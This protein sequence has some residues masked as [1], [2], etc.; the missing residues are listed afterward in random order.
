MWPEGG[1]DDWPMQAPYDRDQISHRPVQEKRSTGNAQEQNDYKKGGYWRSCNIAAGDAA[2]P[3][4]A[5]N[6][7]L[8]MSNYQTSINTQY[9]KI[10]DELRD[11]MTI[12]CL[13]SSNFKAGSCEITE[14]I[15]M[16]NPFYCPPLN[17]KI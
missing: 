11:Q 4:Y 10:I 16:S 7:E 14:G 3:F 2:S 6:Q 1:Q 9:C 12:I 8:N 13:S 17:F 5:T 15:A